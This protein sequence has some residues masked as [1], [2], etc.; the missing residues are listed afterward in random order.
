MNWIIRLVVVASA[1][2]APMEALTAHAADS[3]QPAVP[4][5]PSGADHAGSAAHRLVGVAGC[6]AASCHGGRT[7]IGG[8]ATAWLSRDVNHRRAYDVLFNDVA[9]AMAA[10]L[11][12][13]KGAHNEAR[14]LA[15]HSSDREPQA[16]HG[17]RFTVEFGVGC[18]SCHGA[19]GD[20]IAKHTTRNWKSL[21]TAQK[22]EL[23]FR[24][25][26]PLTGR[27]ETCVACHVGS[28][29]ATVD[30]DLIAAGHPRLAFE[31]SAYH[32]L[33]PKHWDA[34]T[35]IQNDPAQEV[36]LWAIGQAASAKAMADVAAN[37]A[38]Q[39]VH[40]K[41]AYVV[42]DFAEFD[43]N[44]CHHD[45]TEPTR[46][47]PTRPSPLGVPR[48]G[49]WSVPPARFLARESQSGAAAKD[50]LQNLVT[51]MDKSRLSAGSAEELA[52]SAQLSSDHL[53]VWLHSLE[54]SRYDVP[55]ATRLLQRVISAETDADWLPNWDGQTQRYLAIAAASQSLQRLTGRTP[56][57]PSS[58]SRALVP[59]RE[60]LKFPT[61]YATPRGFNP[62]EF[63]QL[64]GQL[65]MSMAR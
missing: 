4:P 53:A 15:C 30:H 41:A 61:G 43:C 29:A 25:L 31:M 6:T 27:T 55:Q 54:S 23:G 34:A 58:D 8:E 10:K 19:A 59:L 17:D 64:L 9:V 46:G 63:D 7:L 40:S 21:P 26:R 39:A 37:R 50:S 13:K 22:A 24:D 51:L 35:E 11:D 1:V 65:R 3:L 18:E 62:S 57:P 45:L 20:W 12:L 42:P 32:T 60:R 56:F 52:K 14:C 48:W 33:L 5:A 16:T 44:A 2:S 36:R 28:P 38:K 49:S 47:R